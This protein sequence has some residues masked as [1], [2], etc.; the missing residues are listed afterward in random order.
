[1]SLQLQDGKGTRSEQ[2]PISNSLIFGIASV[3]AMHCNFW[4][5]SAQRQRRKRD[6]YVPCGLDDDGDDFLTHSL[7]HSQCLSFLSV[8][9]SRAVGQ[10]V[11]PSVTL[12]SPPTSPPFSH[13]FLCRKFEGEIVGKENW[14]AWWRGETEKRGKTTEAATDGRNRGGGGWDPSFCLLLAAILFCNA[15]AAGGRTEWTVQLCMAWRTA[16]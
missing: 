16:R 2:V 4:P 6:S 1:M 3:I 7:T 11:T 12:Q 13:S 10:A 14:P 5:Q 9:G 15:A 8:F